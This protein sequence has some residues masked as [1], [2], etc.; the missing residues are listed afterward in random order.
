[1]V[2]VRLPPGP[3]P[4]AN[5]Q[6]T[7][8]LKRQNG[9][10]L[11]YTG[12]RQWRTNPLALTLELAPE[13]DAALRAMAQQAGLD[14]DRY[15]VRALQE[16]VQHRAALPSPPPSDEATLLQQISEG[17]PVATWQR[18]HALKQQRDAVTLTPAAHAELIALTHEIEI[19]NVRRLELVAALA[20]LRGVSLAAMRDELGLTAPPYA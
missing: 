7:D 19:R 18:Y 8:L 12:T 9:S 6:R 14:P 16:H 17:L 3:P 13:L 4:Q 2:S 20:C 10:R 1:M 15:I 5:H 11:R